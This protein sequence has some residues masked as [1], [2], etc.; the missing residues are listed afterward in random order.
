MNNSPRRWLFFRAARIFKNEAHGIAVDSFVGVFLNEAM[1]LRWV[2]ALIL[3]VLCIQ[4]G[5]LSA[6]H[7]CEDSVNVHETSMATPAVSDEHTPTDCDP[8]SHR[9]SCCHHFVLCL[10]RETTPRFFAFESRPLFFDGV[11]RAISEPYLDG[12]FQPPRG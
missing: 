5:S 4:G 7:G 11:A 3:A 2:V 1:V 6:A 9:I 12:P 8:I 10:A